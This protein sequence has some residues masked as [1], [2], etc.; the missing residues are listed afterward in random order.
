VLNLAGHTFDFGAVVYAVLD[1]CEHHR[2][3][4]AAGE[5][6]AGLRAAAEEKLSQV[7][8]AY[9]ERGGSALYWRAVE[10]EVLET[11]L[12]QYVPAAIE[13]TRLEA[14]RYD[15]WRGGDLLARALFALGAL[16][17]GGLVV[18]IP[19]I[20]IFEDTFAF[21]LALAA[22]FYPELRRATFGFRHARL[23]NH[24]VRDADAYQ[25]KQLKYLTAEELEE[26]L[27]ETVPREVGAAGG[28]LR[29]T[30]A[31]AL[32]SPAKARKRHVRSPS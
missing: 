13:K 11:V 25:K 8:A 5:A 9:D 18:A 32:P 21:G 22:W 17:V 16:A 12:P 26:E 24:L 30:P 1:D 20:P 2:R 19:F 4:F 6:P 15:V 27:D 3:S 7:R 31:V 29:G 28:A 14:S 23:L 10:R